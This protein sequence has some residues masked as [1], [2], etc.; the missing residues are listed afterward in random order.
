VKTS[1]WVSATVLLTLACG[2]SQLPAPLLRPGVQLDHLTVRNLG[3]AGG[4]VD[5]VMAIYNP[6]PI[7]IQGTRLQAGL[8]IEETR[9]GDIGMTNPM[10]LASRDTSLV[11]VPLTFRWAGVG[12]AARSVLS[13][14]AVNYR[15]SGTLTVEA[16]AGF[17]LDVPFSLQGKVPLLKAVTG[18]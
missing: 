15:F 5:V 16:L 6:N 13:Y 18:G 17:P 8:D 7:S 11:T 9:F 3:L 12:A 4:T 2:G 14:G 1:R 10:E